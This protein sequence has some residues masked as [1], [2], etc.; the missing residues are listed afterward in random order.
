M[1]PPHEANSSASLSL[2]ALAVPRHVRRI[3][4]TAA[5]RVIFEESNEC[6]Q[7]AQKKALCALRGCPVLSVLLFQFGKAENQ[8]GTVP[9][10]ITDAWDAGTT[11]LTSAEKLIKLDR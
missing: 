7:L 1:L 5:S 3:Y 6:G 8:N 11:R 9:Y 4:S 10:L 2:K